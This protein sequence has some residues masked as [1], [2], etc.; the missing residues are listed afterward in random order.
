MARLCVRELDKW[1]GPRG[2]LRNVAFEAHSGETI[3]LYGP[4]GCGKTTLLRI[5]AGLE[6]ADHGEI[7]LDG[8]TLNSGRQYAPPEKR[9]AAMVFQNL[10]LWPHMTVEA[11]LN[12]VLRDRVRVRSA[13]ET[14][15]GELLVQFGLS[16][17]ADVRPARLSG[18][19][20]QRL[21]LARALAVDVP[22]L[23]LDE[24]FSH[25]DD[26][27]RARCVEA[28]RAR[29]RA[30]AV[31]VLATHQREDVRSLANIV[32]KIDGEGGVR[33]ER[34]QNAGG[35]ETLDREPDA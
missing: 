2:L 27:W 12:F 15:V 9:S 21:A 19:E 6:P 7:V 35:I 28:L 8:R 1:F 10:A 14:R 20:Q 33:V 31:V 11:H 32:L 24:P 18:G 17:L 30:G 34:T 13:R 5:L 23:L 26:A 4:S 22:L 25:L 16:V 29:A 3:A